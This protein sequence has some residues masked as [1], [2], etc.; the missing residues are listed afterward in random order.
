MST[1]SDS[2]SCAAIRYAFLGGGNMATAMIA[3]LTS[4][5]VTS[6]QIGSQPG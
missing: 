6:G 4:Q 1:T 2:S 5:G 3:G